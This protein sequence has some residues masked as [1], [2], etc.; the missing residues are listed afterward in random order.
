MASMGSSR[1]AAS[2]EAVS[3]GGQEAAVPARFS[4]LMSPPFFGRVMSTSTGTGRSTEGRGLGRRAGAASCTIAGHAEPRRST[5]T[6][7]SFKTTELMR[8]Y[9][10]RGRRAR[11]VGGWSGTTHAHGDYFRADKAWFYIVLLTIGYVVSRGLAK[12]GSREY[13]NGS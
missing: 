12:S 5:E 8:V 1:L 3:A 9:R 10:R 11:R 2:A 13:Y 6:K 4:G 7:A